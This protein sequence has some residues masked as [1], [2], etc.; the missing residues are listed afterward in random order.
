MLLKNSYDFLFLS[1]SLDEDY[2]EQSI[3]EWTK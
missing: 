1:L 2:L 3:Q